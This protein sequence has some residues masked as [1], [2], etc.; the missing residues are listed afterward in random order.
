MSGAIGSVSGP[1]L[2]VLPVSTESEESCLFAPRHGINRFEAA[3][4]IRAESRFAALL[5]AGF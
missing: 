4:G 1:G 5:L 2:K 3:T